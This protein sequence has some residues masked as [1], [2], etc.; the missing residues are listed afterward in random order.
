MVLAVEKEEAAPPVAGEQWGRAR[1]ME[2]GVGKG[3]VG[4]LCY[5]VHSSEPSTSFPGK[6]KAEHGHCWYPS[7][8]S[9]SCTRCFVVGLASTEG[10][11]ALGNALHPAHGRAVVF[12]AV[13]FPS[14]QSRGRAALTQTPN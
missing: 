4:H 8:R 13:V 3:D 10:S 6:R 7:L 9:P 1:R 5:K 12:P 11:P 2:I 14:W